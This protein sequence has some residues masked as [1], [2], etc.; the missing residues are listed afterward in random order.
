[1][2]YWIFSF[3]LNFILD[4]TCSFEVSNKYVHILHDSLQFLSIGYLTIPVRGLGPNPVYRSTVLY[5]SYVVFIL[6]NCFLDF[7]AAPI[8][9]V[10]KV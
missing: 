4:D 5:S 2:L 8:S 10:P 1:M 3:T 6:S 7:S 9:K